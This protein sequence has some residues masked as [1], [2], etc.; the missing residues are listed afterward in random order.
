MA[1]SA[2]NMNHG[3]QYPL[4]ATQAFDYTELESGVAVVAVKVPDG[5][6]VIGGAVYITSAFDASRTIDVGDTADPD[7]YS[8]TPIAASAAGVTALDITGY[9]YPQTGTI[10]L[11]V[12]GAVTQGE[13]Y[14]E[15][16]Y[17][18]DSRAN[19][20]VPSYD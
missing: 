4:V 3:R 13:G 15:V 20:V 16:Q 5:T 19:E 6:R 18:R 1:I 11:T 12:D 8:A 10:D 14:I 7:R 17:I 2:K 9:K